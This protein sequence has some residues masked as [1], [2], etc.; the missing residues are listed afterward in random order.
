MVCGHFVSPSAR[1][2]LMASTAAGAEARIISDTS[3]GRLEVLRKRCLDTAATI[4]Q[5][6]QQ[7]RVANNVD[8]RR[9][10]D[11]LGNR[12]IQCF[13][14][15]R[16]MRQYG[17]DEATLAV[18][19]KLLVPSSIRSAGCPDSDAAWGV[20]VFALMER[21]RVA[22]AANSIWAN[23]VALKHR[24]A[25]RRV[26]RILAEF[27]VFQHLVHMNSKGVAPRRTAM[28]AW[29][30]RHWIFDDVGTDAF[31]NTLHDD[32]KAMKWACRFRRFWRVSWSK[33]P[34]RAAL[35][36]EDQCSKVEGA[37]SSRGPFLGPLLGPVFETVLWLTFWA[38]PMS[39]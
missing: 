14:M 7:A 28:V 27:H 6:R 35:S 19:S 16:L 39:F 23:R 4:K 34:A 36:L 30:Q 22:E 21:P 31:P 15:L 37:E 26:K 9:K 33:L 25:I 24:R 13:V 10:H 17:A 32:R 38:P 12:S 18:I 11:A 3:R 2:R 8:A 5:I 29:L 20:K 1:S